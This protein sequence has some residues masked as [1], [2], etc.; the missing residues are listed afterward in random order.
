MDKTQIEKN[1]RAFILSYCN[2]K[3]FPTG[4]EFIVPRMVEE[5]YNRQGAEGKLKKPTQGLLLELAR[6]QEL[7]ETEQPIEVIE[8]IN[9]ITTRV[10]NRN[11][12]GRTFTEAEVAE[13]LDFETAMYVLQDYLQHTYKRLGE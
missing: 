13:M 12:N 6:L 11:M 8:Q 7:T 10:F 2:L 9:N 4:L 1:V 3:E 5:D